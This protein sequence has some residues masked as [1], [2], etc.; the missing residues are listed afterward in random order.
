MTVKIV[1]CTTPNTEISKEISR[2]LIEK[3]L[4]ACVN[5]LNNIT[6]VYSWKNE[7]CEDNENLLI[8]KT[9]ENKFEELKNEILSIHPYELPEIIMIPAENGL[10][11][12]LN[13]V[14]EQTN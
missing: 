5:I 7:L 3:K 14:R 2:K 6:S 1:F 11:D 4:A 13:W 12:Y 10:K 8:I 9:T